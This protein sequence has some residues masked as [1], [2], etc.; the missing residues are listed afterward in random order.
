MTAF[1]LTPPSTAQ[2]E[3]DRYA[4]WPGQ[5]CSYKIGHTEWVRLREEAKT[6]AGAKFERS[7]STKRNLPL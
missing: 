7:D 1:D 5:A 6:R 4:I 2:R 3:I